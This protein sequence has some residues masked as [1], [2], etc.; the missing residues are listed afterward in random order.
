MKLFNTA[1]A[2]A[3]SAAPLTAFSQVPSTI[4][5]SKSGL[6]QPVVG[7]LTMTSTTRPPGTT[8]QKLQFDFRGT[9]FFY[10]GP[11]QGSQRQWHPH[12]YQLW[13]ILRGSNVADGRGLLI[14]NLHELAVM[15]PS[16]GACPQTGIMQAALFSDSTRLFESS[17]TPQYMRIIDD[18]WY[19]VFLSVSD[20][21]AVTYSI[22]KV[23]PPTTTG[24]QLFT[25]TVTANQIPGQPD[26]SINGTGIF[27]GATNHPQ[28]RAFAIELR[29]I[30]TS[31]Q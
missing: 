11:E 6:G 2:I 9:D 5:I 27:I 17:C 12:S 7:G 10:N 31:W 8:T 18:Q 30:S 23:I 13:V 24:A 4:G 26:P 21:K 28:G 22:H 1:L 15:D 29:Q 20:S 16:F 14:G 3:L 19:R 25:A